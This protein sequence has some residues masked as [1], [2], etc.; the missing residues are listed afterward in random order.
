MWHKGS[1]A[2]TVTAAV[3]QP[4]LLLL[5]RLRMSGSSKKRC[6]DERIDGDPVDRIG[7]LLVYLPTCL[8]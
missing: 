6:A 8:A 2:W 1:L 7:H 3:G 4:L 5:T